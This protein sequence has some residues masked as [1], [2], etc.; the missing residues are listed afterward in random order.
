MNEHACPEDI[1]TLLS[2]LVDGEITLDERARADEHLVACAPCRDLLDLFRK[3][4]A[5]LSNALESEAFGNVIIESVVRSIRREGPPEAD[6][7]GEGP[8]EWLRARPWA[9]LSAAAALL[10]GLTVLVLSQSAQIG[11]LRK[12][13]ESAQVSQRDILGAMNGTQQRYE[14]T[15]RD[16]RIEAATAR[17]KSDNVVGYVE[18]ERGLVVRG[19]FDPREY[20]YFEILRRGPKDADFVKVGA[21]KAPERLARPEYVDRSAVPGQVFAYKFRAVRADGQAVE[22]AP[23][24][25]RVPPGDDLSPDRSIKVHCFDLA[26]SQ[27]VGIFLL[28]RIVN[29]R[30]VV[31]KFVIRPGEAIGA[32]V[33]IAGVGRVDFSTGLTLG[34]IEEGH[35]TLPLSYAEPVLD[36]QNRPVIQKIEGGR[37]V[38][39]TRQHEVP[40]SIRPNQRAACRAEAGGEE[41]LYK[42]SWL[43][44]KAR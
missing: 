28:E 41:L 6:P 15:L 42:G 39:L 1:K 40:L 19:G 12:A 27:D 18:P 5:L 21:P 16:L 25:M 22:S 32:P 43:R 10:V 33:E 29:G 4:D 34:R 44:V 9:P 24:E 7:V 26:V 31:E 14:E 30:P 23:I 17:A 20:A 11:G 3:N 38:P 37:A 2:K 35:Q 8:L 36:E 13:V